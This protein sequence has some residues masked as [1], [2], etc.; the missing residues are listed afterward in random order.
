V[1]HRGQR[2]IRA[3]H[4]TPSD[5]QALAWP[6]VQATNPDARSVDRWYLGVT[7]WDI[8]YYDETVIPQRIKDAQA[9]LALEFL[10]AGTSDLMG[11][12]PDQNVIEKRV[13][14]LTTKYSDPTQRVTGLARF[15][16]VGAL[17]APL[18]VG[19]L[20]VSRR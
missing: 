18:L 3:P 6:R 11:L 8:A 14:V 5:T 1:V 20:T 7:S 15:K 16:R 12:D 9:E 17:L 4:A 10:R 13:D 2:Q 19:A